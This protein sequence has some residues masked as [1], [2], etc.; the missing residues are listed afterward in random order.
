MPVF[1]LYF[2][3]HMPLADVLRLEAIYYVAVVILE[4]PSGYFSDRVGRRP[5]L[6]ISTICA[7]IAC[8]T[9]FL[10]QSPRILRLPSDAVPGR[11]DNS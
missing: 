7:F 9:F 5:T 2:L 3:Q 11:I 4:V 10:G 8:T 6:L 1:V